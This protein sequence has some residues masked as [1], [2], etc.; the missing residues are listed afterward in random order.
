MPNKK[1]T[2][3][4]FPLIILAIVFSPYTIVKLTSY[5]EELFSNNP[6]YQAQETKIVD[7]QSQE[8]K[9]LAELTKIDAETKARNEQV[10]AAQAEPSAPAFDPAIAPG[11]IRAKIL[12]ADTEKAP[13]FSVRIKFIA[14]GEKIFET[15]TDK[16]GKIEISLNSGRYYAEVLPEDNTYRLKGDAPAFF[17]EANS[18]KDLGELDLI[19]K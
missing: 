17:L 18:E 10:A 7:Y 3:I 11:V 5:G 13:D 4:I 19:K 6:A 16:S 12:L 8:Q 9:D 2:F 1:I 15:K 14:V